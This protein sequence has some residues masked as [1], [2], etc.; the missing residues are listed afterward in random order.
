MK[1]GLQAHRL[2]ARFRMARVLKAG[3][4]SRL[5]L[6]CGSDLDHSSGTV[7]PSLR[8][9][10]RLANGKGWIL[11]TK[12]VASERPAIDHIVMVNAVRADVPSSGKPRDVPRQGREKGRRSYPKKVLQ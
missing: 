9:H 12:I 10:R 2:A 4:P 6:T 5:A 11:P 8:C 7:K 1:V 3:D